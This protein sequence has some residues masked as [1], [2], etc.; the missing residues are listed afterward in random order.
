LVYINAKYGVVLLKKEPKRT[1]TQTSQVPDRFFT[2]KEGNEALGTSLSH[3][4]MR[5]SHSSE[6]D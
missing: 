3:S 1:L 2:N 6:E 5:L 4:G